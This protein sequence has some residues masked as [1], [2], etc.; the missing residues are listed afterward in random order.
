MEKQSKKTELS[1]VN[2]QSNQIAVRDK[3]VALKSALCG[4]FEE[5]EEI[6]T[7]I[8][9]A[10]VIGEHVVLLG[11][12]GTGKSALARALCGSVADAKFFELMLTRYS[13]PNELF[14]GIDLPKWSNTG[15]YVRCIEGMLP[16]ANIAFIDE[17]FKANSSILNAMLSIL[18][19]RVY[20]ERGKANRV[21]LHTVVAASN[22][23]PEGA[24][25]EALYD[26]FLVRFEVAY[27]REQSA[28]ERVLL[29]AEPAVAPSLVLA[30]LD[31]A[32]AEALA[33]PLG[34]G[35]VDALFHLR[36]TL[37]AE[38]IVVSDRRWKK[39]LGLLK[40]NAYLNGDSEVDTIHFEILKHGLWRDPREFAKIASIV[41]KVASPVLLE[42][43]EVFDAI[44]E[45]A[46]ALPVDGSIKSQGAAVGSEMKKAVKRIEEMSKSA[47]PAVQARIAPMVTTLKNQHAALV[48]R[49]TAELGL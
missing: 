23:T 24:E 6:V 47:S 17:I 26:R 14:G 4:V 30:D 10:A 20:H 37:G 9:A 21:P 38:G 46:N 18:N 8:I 22:E 39:L 25:L 27:V 19:E 3:F 5:R 12:A 13:E 2:T 40:A 48:S 49:I 45:Q 16:T 35:V 44:M 29:G 1:L 28:F 33:L 32:R 36:G 15:E 11:P 41:I 43:T 7:G 42:A 34:A 31:A